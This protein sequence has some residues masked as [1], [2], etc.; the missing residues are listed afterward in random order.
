MCRAMFAHKVTWPTEAYF[1][2]NEWSI[3]LGKRYLDV[4]LWFEAP[5][6]LTPWLICTS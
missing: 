6:K 1:A 2:V 3:D 5:K 4:D